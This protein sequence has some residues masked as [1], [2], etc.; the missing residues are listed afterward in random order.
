VGSA[1]VTSGAVTCVTSSYTVGG[2]VAG[3]AGT[4]LVLQNNGGNNLPVS[5]NGGFTFGTPVASG[6]AYAV[7]VLTQPTS[8]AQTCAVTGGAGTVGSA[9]VTN[10][11]VTCP[12]PSAC[13]TGQTVCGGACV[14]I[15]TGVAGCALAFAEQQLAATASR[16]STSVSPK[17][18]RPDGSWTTI[19]NTDAVAW[20]Q[21]FFPGCLWI[22]YEHGGDPSWLGRAAAWTRALDGQKDNTQT[23]DL[24]FKLMTS[25]GRGYRMTQDPYY[26]EVLLTAAGSLAKRYRPIV[27]A[28]SAGDWNPDWQLP[29]FIDTMVNLELLLWAAD[30]GGEPEWREMATSHALRTLAD[31]VRA[32]GST[33]HVADYDPTSGTMRWRG[34]Y[35]GYSDE[36]TWARGQA[37]AMYGFTVTYRYTADPRMLAAARRV[38]EYWISHLAAGPVPNWDFDAPTEQR[39]SSAAAAAASALFELSDLV[40]D[41]PTRSRYRSAAFATLHA[42][43]SP[44]YL[45]SGTV[46]QGILLHGVGF[47]PASLEVDVSL[48]Y[49]DYYLLEAVSRSIMLTDLPPGN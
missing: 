24:G 15:G 19:A 11:A 3:L 4:G 17:A 46:S 49:G 31:L 18:T 37:W 36:S 8:P 28:L 39:D 44:A 38:T 20:T 13:P 30:N 6:G 41:E 9:N 2:T 45:A 16:L 40:A 25:F 14:A 35:Q 42:L 29:V 23:H 7:T 22:M 10:V 33:T 26:K 1:D 48:I 5:A 27:G 47:L 43:V 34:T 32:D 21:G 12:P